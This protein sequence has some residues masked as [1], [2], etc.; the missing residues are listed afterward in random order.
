MDDTETN[1][2]GINLNKT[3]VWESAVPPGLQF[4][5]GVV[6]NLIALVVLVTSAKSHKW[7]PF[8]RLVGGLALTD[9]GGIL[10]VY[11]TV[12]VRYAT[13]FTY[14]FPKP[15]CDYSSFIY[16]FT[17][18]SS[19]MIVCA[20]SLDRFWA[21]LF[22][23]KYNTN[24]KN[25]RTNIMLIS[26]WIAGAFISS[27]QLMGLGSSFNYY[28]GSW[29]FLNFVGITTMDRLS[30][31]IYSLFGLSIL[32]TTIGLNSIVILT[33]CRGMNSDIRQQQ[34]A[35]RRKKN[36]IFIVIFLMI[37]V[38]VFGVCW[39][40][41]MVT[42]LGHAGRWIHGN[43]ARELLVLRFAV[44]NSII[45]PWIYILLRKET[46]IAMKRH[47]RGLCKTLFDRLDIPT[48]S[49]LPEST[50]NEVSGCGKSMEKTISTDDQ[51][52]ST[53]LHKL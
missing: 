53:I 22:P 9:G 49:G 28:P 6:G 42:I 2:S 25:R 52:S 32:L 45:D 30:S 44:T 50:P 34:T 37:I 46:F 47:S 12:M 23:F 11:P 4:A 14:D 20:M 5:L 18:I 51:I 13:D 16:T 27:L 26:I 38:T 15:L 21:I 19:A 43:G 31:Y 7:K 1:S 10:L 41:L 17:L 29:C 3:K 48:E 36:D 24:T 40:P 8:Y 33:V 39:T 35:R